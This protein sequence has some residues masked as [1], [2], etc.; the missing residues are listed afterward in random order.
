MNRYIKEH[1]NKE[2]NQKKCIYL[3]SF[4]DINKEISE[5]NKIGII[6]FDGSSYHLG[7]NFLL[8]KSLIENKGWLGKKI[9]VVEFGNNKKNNKYPYFAFKIQPVDE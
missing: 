7:E 2:E 9:I 1:P 8:N 3:E 4:D 5:D 6:E